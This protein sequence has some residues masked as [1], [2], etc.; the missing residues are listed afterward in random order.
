VLYVF[1]RCEEAPVARLNLTIPDS[2][3]SRLER[4]RDRVNVSKVC[5]MALEKELAMLETSPMGGADPKVQRMLERL[6]SH[7]EKWY[8]R[9]Y[10]D[11]ENWAVEE[12]RAEELRLMGEEW[13]DDGEY[14]LDEEA[15]QSV[16]A[17]KRIERWVLGD[18]EKSGTAGSRGRNSDAY[19][20]A[21]DQA[22][23]WAYMNGWHMAVRDLWGK[24]A[25]MLRRRGE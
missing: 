5:A 6:Q 20:K 9:G 12:A 15:W 8:R 22:D 17:G 23:E 16:E 24:V 1:E 2:L 25:P 18:L 13:E 7:Q 21:R 19:E 14:D 4:W 10:E 11:G 3:Y